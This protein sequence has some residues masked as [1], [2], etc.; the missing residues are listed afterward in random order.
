MA[1]STKIAGVSAV[2]GTFFVLAVS[3]VDAQSVVRSGDTVSIAEDQVIEGDFYS[4]ANIINVSGEVSEDALLVGGQVTVNGASG[5]DLLIVSGQTD[6][7][8][9]VGDDLRIVAGEVTIAEPVMGD[10]FV[11]AGTVHILS[12]ASIAGDLLMY[13]GQATVEGSVGGDVM[14][15]VE[16]LRI[17]AAVAGDVDVTVTQLT[18]GDRAAVNGSVRYVSHELAVLA[19]NHMVGG[20]VLRNDPVLPGTDMTVKAALIPVLV[21]LFSVLVWYLVSRRSLRTVVSRAVVRSPRPVLLGVVT[22]LVMPFVTAV[23]LFSVLGT[24]VGIISVLG[25]MLLVLLGMVAV[26]AILG[27][28][29]LKVF[30]QP[31]AQLSLLS[32]VVGVVGVSLLMLLPVLGQVLILALLLVAMGAMVDALIRPEVT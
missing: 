28:L 4:A 27:Q 22:L 17:D 26:P 18:L 5:D 7:H 13:A 19:P 25:Y 16:N 29:L 8:G 23:L 6:I 30:N 9:T 20:D 11:A 3:V 12:T 24:M 2:V 15:T 21:L 14:G 1:I 32:L 31:N 10:V